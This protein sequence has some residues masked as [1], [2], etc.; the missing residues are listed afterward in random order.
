MERLC[1]V[2]MVFMVGQSCHV[3]D[4]ELSILQLPPVVKWTLGTT[5]EAYHTLSEI[6]CEG[7]VVTK[8]AMKARCCGKEAI[9]ADLQLCC[10][11]NSTI[12]NR[13]S[14]HHLCCGH[15][16]YNNQ[17]H[18]CD[19]IN[20]SLEISAK[21]SEAIDADL[22]LCCG[23]NS[24]ILNRTSSHHLCCGHKQYNNQTHTC[25]EINGSL[26]ISAKISGLPKTSTDII[27]NH[28]TQGS[29]PTLNKLQI[30]WRRNVT[31]HGGNG[32]ERRPGH[33]GGEVKG[34]I[35]REGEHTLTETV[36]LDR[37]G[38]GRQRPPVPGP[39]A[40]L[41]TRRSPPG[42]PGTRNTALRQKE[43]FVDQRVTTL[44]CSAV[45][46]EHKQTQVPEAGATLFPLSTIQKHTPAAMAV[47]L[48]GG[49]ERI[50]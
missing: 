14:S 50:Q 5:L 32:P 40:S 25:D 12:L 15:K 13:T 9:D 28:L 44:V 10:G 42:L 4:C 37:M 3:V 8:P 34:F 39:L 29:L 43:A 30:I 33:S 31:I 2:R 11:P 35:Y 49:L 22:Q 1:A 16:Q 41:Q 23:P 7:T 18:T 48:N 46:R 45:V 38:I 27:Y 17:T 6:C 47:Y 24:T 21:I 19:E 36:L 26:E 20:G